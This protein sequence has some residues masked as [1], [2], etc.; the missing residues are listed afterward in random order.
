MFAE[1]KPTFE[2]RLQAVRAAN[3]ARRNAAFVDY[4]PRVCGMTL[5]P[6]TLVRSAALLGLFLA[7]LA[8]MET[9]SFNP[10]LYFQF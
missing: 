5:R 10:F 7:A 1:H 8:V 2:E 3:A 6:V 9:Q 4:L